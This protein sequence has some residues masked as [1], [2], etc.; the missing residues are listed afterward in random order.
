MQPSAVS[1]ESLKLK[2]DMQS[3]SLPFNG[4]IKKATTGVQLHD[5]FRCLAAEIVSEGLKRLGLKDA[6]ELKDIYTLLTRP[7]ETA[8]GDICY[9]CFALSKAFRSA[10]QK[11][12]ESLAKEINQFTT[13]FSAEA[14]GPYV[15]LKASNSVLKEKILLRILSREVFQT[16]LVN[17]SPVTMLE[18]SQ[19]NTHKELHVGHLRNMC[20]GL[21]LENCLKYAGFEIYT[22]TFP[23]DVGTHVAKCL[24]Y[25]KN[26][27]KQDAPAKGKGAWLGNMYSQ[28]VREFEEE[29]KDPAK[30]EINSRELTKILQELASGKGEYFDSWKETRAW[31]LDQLQEVY[32]WLGIKFDKW[33]YE[34]DVDHR[35]VQMVK[36]LFADGKIIESKGALGLDLSEKGLG[37]CLLLK[38]DGNGLYATKD[39]LLACDKF[40]GFPVEKSVVVVDVRQTHHFAQVFAALEAIGIDNSSNCYHLPYN[41]VELPDG[42]MSSRLG[43]IIPLQSLISTMQERIASRYLESYRGQWSDDEIAA[44]T[45]IIAEGAIKFGMNALDPNTKI[46]FNMDDWISLDKQSGPYVQY[47]C[48]RIRSLLKK[49]GINEAIDDFKMDRLDSLEERSLILVLGELNNVV[50]AISERLNSSLMCSYLLDVCRAF[51]RFYAEHKVVV[52]GDEE[53]TRA[54]SALSQST[55]HILEQGLKLLAID[56]P[57][58]M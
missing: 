58:R 14:V 33:Y 2:H 3:L 57:Q 21:A 38:A 23:G 8:L 37:F 13:V 51:N 40:A 11:I 20:L 55:I 12:A 17:N 32:S 7:P 43:N 34:S 27:N 31:S 48:A 42:P 49:A 52:P 19:P 45:K 53:L 56:V 4:E 46:V 44:A 41:F 28:A 9:P 22:S 10:P 5:G 30:A 35:S 26:K 25:L 24:W 39:L 15:N 36:G 18:Y 50:V 16:S 1:S 47:T 54:R 29:G 6:F